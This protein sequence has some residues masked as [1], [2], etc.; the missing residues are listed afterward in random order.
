M[1]SPMT[2]P[3]GVHGANCFARSTGNFAKLLVARC[4][5]SFSASGPSTSCSAMWCDWSNRT[6]VSRH[7]R[8]SSRQFEYSDGTTGYTY[9][10]DLRIAEHGDGISRRPQHVFQAL[11]AHDSP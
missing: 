11:V 6:Q 5:N 10:A 9:A 7:A 1:P 3:Y 2:W 4:E 8:C